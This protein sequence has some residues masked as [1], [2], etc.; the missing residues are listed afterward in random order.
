MTGLSKPG[1][2]WTA[3]LK[4]VDTSDLFGLAG[5]V[6]LFAGLYQVDKPLAFI[7]TGGLLFAINLIG[8]FRGRQ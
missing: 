1:S 2:R 6:L 3:V 7:V 8:A 4:G 5:L